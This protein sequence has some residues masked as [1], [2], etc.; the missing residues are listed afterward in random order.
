MKACIALILPTMFLSM[1]A[2]AEQPAALQDCR[3]NCV[4]I[5]P[6]GGHI[7]EWNKYDQG[8]D[9]PA[10]AEPIDPLASFRTAWAGHSR[11]ATTRGLGF[12]PGAIVCGGGANVMASYRTAA[13]LFERMGEANVTA[14][15]PANMR[16]VIETYGDPQQSRAP[17]LE[18]YGCVLIPPG[19][20][21]LVLT[22]VLV[23]WIAAEVDGRA[24]V[25]ATLA[26]MIKR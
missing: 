6:N 13:M 20:H 26:D 1:P 18:A 21:V 12:V 5:V 17:D 3:P 16:A 19:H 9:P 11:E 22:A 25:G 10:P 14:S 15:L 7:A 24:V 8:A 23:P 4:I 2:S